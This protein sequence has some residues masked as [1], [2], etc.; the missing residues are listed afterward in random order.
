ME[1]LAFRAEEGQGPLCGQKL[2]KYF[3]AVTAHIRRNKEACQPFI[4]TVDIHFG[5]F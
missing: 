3:C 5:K 2:S 1:N 4:N